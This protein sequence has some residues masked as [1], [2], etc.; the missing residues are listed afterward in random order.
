MIILRLY[1]P[2]LN[3]WVTAQSPTV[4]SN[5]PPGRRQE[6]HFQDPMVWGLM[7]NDKDRGISDIIAA[8]TLASLY[9]PLSFSF[10]NLAHVSPASSLY[11]FV[12]HPII[13]ALLGSAPLIIVG[14][15]ATESLLI[16]AAI[17]KQGHDLE[18]ASSVDSLTSGAITAL[19]GS[20][21]IGA[22]PAE[23]RLSRKDSQPPFQARF[24]KCATKERMGKQNALILLFPDRL[25]AVA[26]TAVVTYLFGLDKHGVAIVGS[27]DSSK[28]HFPSPHW[29]FG[30]SNKGQLQSMATTSM[31]VAAL[32]LSNPQQRQNP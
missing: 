7:S 31:L 24:H 17:Q 3:P 32:G 6:N 28:L 5:L 15:E 20:M 1:Q 27:M 18:S 11:A 2:T 14:P 26:A 19:A 9:I 13:Y 30:V 12:F 16:G 8:L 4:N 10:A 21:L 29:P 23:T 25:V 22:G